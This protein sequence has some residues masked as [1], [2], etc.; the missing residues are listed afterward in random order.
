MQVVPV[1]RET[2]ERAALEESAE[3]VG[4]AVL[5]AREEPEVM[6]AVLQ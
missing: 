4:R 1:P 5:E 2:E 6:V 3:E